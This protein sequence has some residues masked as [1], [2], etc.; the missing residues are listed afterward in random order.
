MDIEK[1][2][3]KV[4]D[5]GDPDILPPEDFGI[6]LDSITQSQ[7]AYIAFALGTFLKRHWF[8]ESK[9]DYR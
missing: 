1:A 8:V 2:F 9:Y 7:R 3:E 5:E 6:T 4:L